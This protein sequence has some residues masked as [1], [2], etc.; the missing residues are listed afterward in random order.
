[1]SGPLKRQCTVYNNKAGFSAGGIPIQVAG[2]KVTQAVIQT[3]SFKQT[4]DDEMRQCK[5]F[6]LINFALGEQ[7]VEVVADLHHRNIQ[8]IC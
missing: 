5:Y 1:M 3:C 4:N 8:V 6:I 7:L 2:K